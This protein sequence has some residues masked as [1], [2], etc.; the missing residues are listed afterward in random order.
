VTKVFVADLRGPE[1]QKHP[2]GKRLADLLS[3]ALQ[4]DFPGLQDRRE[5]GGIAETD[6]HPVAAVVPIEVTFRLY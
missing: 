1:D 4:R 6:G 3:T 5:E 2:A